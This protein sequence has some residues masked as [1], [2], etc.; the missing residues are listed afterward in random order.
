MTEISDSFRGLRT[1]VVEDE[2]LIAEEIRE[3]L[4]RH[5]MQVV[6]V[7]DTGDRAIDMAQ[8]HHPE[9]VLMDIRL[10]G[11][12]DG[13]EAAQTIRGELAGPVVFLTA[14]SDQDTLRRAMGADPFG[15]VLKPLSER[16]LLIAIDMA[17]HRHQLEKRLKESERRFAA[18]L[19]SI[20]DGVIATDPE[21]R[22]T[23]MNPVAEALTGRRD[24]ET[25]GMDFDQVFPLVDEQSG[26]ALESPVRR[27]LRSR[28]VVTLDLPAILVGTEGAK[29]L[30]DDSASPITDTGGAVLGAVVAFRDI[31]PRRLAEDAL[32]QA[33]EQLRHAQRMDAIG[34]LAG[35]VAHDFNNLLMVIGGSTDMLLGGKDLAPTS[36]S[37]LQ[38]IRKAAEQAAGLTGRLLA[39]GRKQSLHPV[40]VDIGA[41]IGELARML[42]RVLGEDIVLTT[43][44]PPALW[45]VRADPGQ[46]EQVLLNLAI[47]SRDAMP[48]GGRLAIEAE[49]L[50]VDDAQVRERPELREGPYVR[51]TVTDTG[52]GMDRETCRHAFEPFFTTKDPGKGTGLGLATAYGIV[53]QS[54]GFIYIRSEVGSGTTVDLYLP[55]L[56]PPSAAAAPL[57]TG[58]QEEVKGGD[59]TILLVEDDDSVRSLIV[60]SLQRHGY[61]IH[62]AG[63]G[64]EALAL[65]SEHADAVQLVLTDVVMPGMNG[66]EV[67][68]ALE[69]RKDGL[70]VMFIS[71]HTDDQVLHHGAQRGELPFMQKPFTMSELAERVREVLDR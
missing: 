17:L 71:G 36:R 11:P 42:T 55:A 64:E 48:R 68:E 65:F 2:V 54:G 5:G 8:Q 6:A 14:H 41:L 30:I 23:F 7:V 39:F 3:R 37:L 52:A 69:G 56:S 67:W 24:A 31:R 46:L 16:E 9:L 4:T 34:R 15:Y 50:D 45:S 49:N 26:G 40:R 18:T 58:F 29:I 59:E 27:A 28:S 1:M 62:A 63:N 33:Q 51:I 12:L 25:R 10:K 20:G 47:N 44:C 60:A 19:A 38:D 22:V 43:T 57:V 13:I 61:T 32:T 21:A 35:G 53:K 66:R 70:R